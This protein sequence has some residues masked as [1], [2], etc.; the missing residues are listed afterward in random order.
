MKSAI[1]R[2]VFVKGKE[3]SKKKKGRGGGGEFGGENESVMRFS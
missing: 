3:I 1:L 2:D